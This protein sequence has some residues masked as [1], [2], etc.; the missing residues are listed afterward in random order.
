MTV[1]AVCTEAPSKYKCPNCKIVYCS[2]ICYKNHK[3]VPC[4]KVEAPKRVPSV[5]AFS[6]KKPHM[7]R[8]AKAAAIEEEK[9]WKISESQFAKLRGNTDLCA[10]L[11]DPVLQ[12]KLVEIDNARDRDAALNKAIATDPRFKDFA[13]NILVTIGAC[14]RSLDGT[15]F[16][17][18]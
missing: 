16:F 10:A 13:D 6:T 1:C 5:D 12:A 8:H 18:A 4:T 2:L 15:V 11:R 7:T 14:E 9:S 17:V 3:E